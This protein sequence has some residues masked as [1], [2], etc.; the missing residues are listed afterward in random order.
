MRVFNLAIE[1]TRRCN[2]TC[3]SCL[4]GDAE[5][6]D[7][8]KKQID[9]ILD[10]VDEINEVTLSGGE[11]TLCL[12]I[13]KYFFEKAE[14][15]G[16]YPDSFYL[17]TNGMTNQAELAHILLDAYSKCDD[18]EAC[19]VS[20]SLDDF[21]DGRQSDYIKGLA[22]YSPVKARRGE[23]P[24]RWAIRMGRADR[25]GIGTYRDVTTRFSIDTDEN[26]NDIQRIEIDMI[27]VSANGFVYP[28]CDISYNIMDMNE[29]V[30]INQIRPYF[31]EAAQTE[32][33]NELEPIIDE[34]TL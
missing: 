3:E 20:L 33:P 34:N 32:N 26:Q 10:Q 9:E 15:L 24:E 30:R 4:R 5:N 11:P 12:D 27:Y 31:Y 17:A 18:K 19:A 7:M 2:M 14:Q 21:H 16:K 13:I 22:F 29:K 6:I 1:V 8:T 25:N 28:D 23:D